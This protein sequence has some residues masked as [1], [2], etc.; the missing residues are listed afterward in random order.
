[1]GEY[2]PNIIVIGC[3]WCIS[4]DN[5]II[6]VPCA[7]RVEPEFILEALINGADGVLVVG[8]TDCRYVRGSTIAKRR[9]KMLQKVLTELGIESERVRL[10]C[11]DPSKFDEVMKEFN[12]TIK[13]LGSNPL[14][15]G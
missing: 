5:K 13:E 11:I 7:G 14:R 2:E 4:E 10:E 1:M 6:K 8:C 9:V 15:R 12:S 3:N